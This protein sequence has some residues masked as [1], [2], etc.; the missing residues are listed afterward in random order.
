[1]HFAIPSNRA[2]VEWPLD[3]HLNPTSLKLAIDG[4]PYLNGRTNIVHALELTFDEVLQLWNGD[5]SNAN[6]LVVLIADGPCSERKSEVATMAARLR[7]KAHI[8]VIGVG[9]RIDRAELQSIASI[10]GNV[11]EIGSFLELGTALQAVAGCPVSST[12]SVAVTTSESTEMTTS[13]ST[14]TA[15]P[16]KIEHLLIYVY[17]IRKP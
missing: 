4:L 11:V 13:V 1:M 2:Q 7:T 14:T 8:L 15:R 5:R 9:D 12:T 16:G 6:N 10:P 3:R 17:K